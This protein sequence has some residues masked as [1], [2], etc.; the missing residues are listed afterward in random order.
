M[1]KDDWNKFLKG[2]ETQKMWMFRR[3][4]E[5]DLGIEIWNSPLVVRVSGIN[6]PLDTH[7]LLWK[8]DI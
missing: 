3:R 1:D 4:I 5:K 2:K 6:Y 8:E 7:I